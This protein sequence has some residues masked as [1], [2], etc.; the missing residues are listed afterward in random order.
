VRVRTWKRKKKTRRNERRWEEGCRQIR[1]GH[2]KAENQGKQRE[3]REGR[4]A[5]PIRL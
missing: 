3:E 2:G 4:E 5:F 1:S